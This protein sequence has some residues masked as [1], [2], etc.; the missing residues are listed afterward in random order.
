MKF[1]FYG[2]FLQK[3]TREGVGIPGDGK[4]DTV[5]DYATWGSHIVTAYEN[6]DAGIAL[7][8]LVIDVPESSIPRLDAIEAG[9]ERKTITTVRG[10]SVQMYV[11]K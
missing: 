2:I 7:T 4:Y 5:K 10:E 11:G 1:F 9:Y 3:S 8:G 6:P